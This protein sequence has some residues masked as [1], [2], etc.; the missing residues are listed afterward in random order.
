MV[1]LTYGLGSSYPKLCQ[2]EHF[3]FVIFIL[4]LNT[5]FFVIFWSFKMIGNIL[6]LV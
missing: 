2:Q 6:K 5:F 3:F 1:Q 4:F